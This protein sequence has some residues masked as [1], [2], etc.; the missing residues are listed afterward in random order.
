MMKYEIASPACGGF[1]MT[2]KTAFGGFAMMDKIYFGGAM[3]KISI[4]T[5]NFSSVI[6]RSPRLPRGVSRGVYRGTTK[7]SQCNV[8]FRI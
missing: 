4:I 5:E 8:K 6:A 2:D 7:Q 1:A 3:T